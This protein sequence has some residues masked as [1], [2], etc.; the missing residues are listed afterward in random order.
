MRKLLIYIICGLMTLGVFIPSIVKAADPSETEE[1]VYSIRFNLIKNNEYIKTIGYLKDYVSLTNP[2]MPTLKEDFLNL[3]NST[4]ANIYNPRTRHFYTFGQAYDIEKYTVKSKNGT[5]IKDLSEIKELQESYLVQD[6]RYL[7]ICVHVKNKTGYKVYFNPDNGEEGFTT[8]ATFA[9]KIKKSPKDPTR[10]GYKFLGWYDG[11]KVF[12]LPTSKVYEDTTL[13]AKWEKENFDKYKVSFVL[14][15]SDI[16]SQ[17]VEF[18]TN[19]TEPK[20]DPKESFEF[21]GW[22]TDSGFTSKFD[23]SSPIKSNLTLYARWTKIETE[24]P[25]PDED[26]DPDENPGETEEPGEDK[27][28]DDDEKENPGDDEKENP[29][30]DKKPEDNKDSDDQKNPDIDN[31]PNK[32]DRPSYDYYWHPNYDYLNSNR[33][34]SSDIAKNKD[35]NKEEILEEKVTIPEAILNSYFSDIGDL[36]GHYQEA[37]ID[38]A[39]RSVLIG[40]GK[41]NFDPHT[42][43]S[44]AMV[45]QV[46][47]RLA[48]DKTYV[49]PFDFTDVSPTNWFYTAVNWA[50]EKEL[51]EGF[52]DKTFKPNKSIT[53]EELAVILA[54][55]IEKLELKTSNI[56]SINKDDYKFLSD[57]NRDGIIKMLELGLMDF[58]FEGN[59]VVVKEISRAEFANI[60]YKLINSLN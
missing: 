52:K 13:T 3:F 33:N 37:I 39:N 50:N 18:D 43:I 34:N 24:N 20:V 59:Q 27:K 56:N 55:A 48:N 42:S 40:T 36:P 32:N 60:I 17:K 51:V 41:N 54:R 38:L 26:K 53:N 31:N 4:D 8:E 46:L 5:A 10:D 44:R 30:E 28:P 6:I 35:E 19:A 12:T 16:P 2:E 29:D 7:L 25:N 1:I 11:D 23:F 22:Y 14:E 21:D 57:W 45:A 49:N 58:S 15:G 47:Y 9:S